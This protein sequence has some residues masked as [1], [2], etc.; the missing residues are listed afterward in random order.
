M[1]SNRKQDS[2]LAPL[3]IVQETGEVADNRLVNYIWVMSRNLA[4]LF[5]NELQSEPSWN[6]RTVPSSFLLKGRLV[7]TK[8]VLNESLIG[9]LA[10]AQAKDRLQDI[11]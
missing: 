10:V 3:G 6:I 8:R 9:T 5:Q 4:H 2:R 1:K 11:S 7:H